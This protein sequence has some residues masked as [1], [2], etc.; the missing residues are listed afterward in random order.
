VKLLIN[1]TTL[2]G[3]GVT[4]VA[5]SFINECKKITDNNYIIFLSPVVT[6]EIDTN[7]FPNNFSF[8][9]FDEFPQR[10]FRGAKVRRRLRKLENELKPDVTFSVFGPSYWTPRSSH[11]QGYAYPHY[12]YEESPFFEVITFSQRVQNKIFKLLHKYFLTRNGKYFVGETEDVTRRTMKYLGLTP[13]QIYHVSNT[14]NEYFINFRPLDNRL[15][16]SK[17]DSEFRLLCLCSFMPHKNLEIL[18]QVIPY[19]KKKSSKK[20]TFILTVDEQL[21][22]KKINA[23]AKESIINL[24]RVHVKNCP[25]LYFET[26]ALFLPTLLECFSANYPEAMKMRKPIITSNLSFAKEIAG[27]AAVY[28]DPLDFKNIANQIMVLSN[29]KDLQNLLIRKGEERLNYFN[30]SFVRA[31]KYLEICRKI[32]NA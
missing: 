16:P 1:T 9:Y 28:F 14:F 5:V 15:L 3:T 7:T 6:K 32:S 19:L 12:I 10:L 20:I 13:G 11:L 24:G 30:S 27:D 29:D 8:Y 18:N 4:Q 23:I 2:I 31:K 22:S 25:Q 26:D 21:F 17:S